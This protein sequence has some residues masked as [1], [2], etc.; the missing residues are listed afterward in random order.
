MISEDLLKILMNGCEA[1]WDP[2]VW[3]A[4]R[5]ERTIRSREQP[6]AP[7]LKKLEIVEELGSAS[8]SLKDFMN[9]SVSIDLSIV[10]LN[11]G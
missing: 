10:E 8:L 2:R 7:Y 3:C 5:A 4:V 1:R 6:M 9:P 11:D